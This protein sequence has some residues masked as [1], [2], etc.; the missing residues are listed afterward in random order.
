[1]KTSEKITIR[2][3]DSY[4]RMLDFLVEVDDS[5]TRSEAIR[6]AIRNY[7]YDRTDLVM[8][9]LQKMREAE[10]RLADIKEFREEYLLK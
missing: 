10:K 8:E 1:M 5:P 6:E 7:I 3:P 4:I 2:L 9:K